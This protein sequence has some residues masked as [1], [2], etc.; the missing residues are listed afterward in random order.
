MENQSNQSS[1]N[2]NIA[3]M[4]SGGLDSTAL[5]YKALKEDCSELS[6]FY[7]DLLNN[8]EQNEM[9]KLACEELA[10]KL[11]QEFPNKAII[12]SIISE[13]CTY[14]RGNLIELPQPI[15]WILSGVMSLS[16]H[17]DEFWLGYVSGDDAVG[18]INEITDLYKSYQPFLFAGSKLPEIKFPLIHT[19]KQQLIND[20]PEHFHQSIS[21]CEQPQVTVYDESIIYQH[22]N[23][24]HSCKVMMMYTESPHNYPIFLGKYGV[25]LIP[26]YGFTDK[27]KNMSLSRLKKKRFNFR[28]DDDDQDVVEDIEPGEVKVKLKDKLV[29]L[30]SKEEIEENESLRGES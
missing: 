6:L 13:F 26:R 3:I 22:C 15:I 30:F 18:K 11:R 19:P 21:F 17:V 27:R 14:S 10:V 5:A 20:L 16:N 23:K 24:C 7:V 1:K 25:K 2:K 12:F 8:P 4:F 9:Q 29:K 28:T